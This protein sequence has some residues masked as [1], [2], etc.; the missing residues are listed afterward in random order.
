[1][2]KNT[3]ELLKDIISIP[4]YPDKDIDERN[5]IDYIIKFFNENTSYKIEEQAVNGKR[6]NLIAMNKRDPKIILFGH[7]DTVPPKNETTNPFTPK[8]ED[9]KLFGLGA[10]DMKSGLAIMLNQAQKNTSNDIGFVFSVDEEFDFQGANKLKE[11]TD[12]KP[13]TIINLEPTDNKILN[14]CRGVTEFSFDLIGKSSHAGRKNLGINSI[15]KA[16]EIS[17][18]LQEEVSKFD[19]EDAKSSVNLAYLHG[20][21]LEKFVDNEP[22][23]KRMGNIVPDYARVVIE[24]RLAS[25]KITQEFISN[26]IN[27]KSNQLGT[28]IE[29]L[30]FKFYLGSMYTPKSDLVQF[31]RAIE[32]SGQ[33]VEY[34]NINSSGYFELQMLQEKWGGN[35]IVYGAGP[36]NMSH[37]ANEYVLISTVEK[38]EKVIENF[39]KENL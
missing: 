19:T 32:S 7:M 15:E 26:T 36:G 10:V 13:Q 22:L 4:S 29:N 1:M 14:G 5:I 24:I 9:D 21:V 31:E 8:I 6:R 27:N 16:I 11:I 38:A 17:N 30:E 34:S 39:I 18:N 37:A 28:R 2:T 12:I 35:C 25:S 3:I 33:T 20:G 23:V